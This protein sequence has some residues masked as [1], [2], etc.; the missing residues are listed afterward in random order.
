MRQFGVF[1]HMGVDGISM[2]LIL[3]NSFMTF[4]VVVAGWE[5]IEEKVAGHE[6]LRGVDLELPAKA[7]KLRPR[8]V[9]TLRT[10]YAR[11]GFN[12]ALRE[13]DGAPA[14]VDEADD[15]SQQGALAMA[16]EADQARRDVARIGLRRGQAAAVDV[17]AVAQ[18][19]KG[20]RPTE[21]WYI[22]DS[23]ILTGKGGERRMIFT[24]LYEAFFT[25]LKVAFFGAALFFFAGPRAR[26]AR[27]GL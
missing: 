14:P 18:G 17:D 5:V 26:R 27:R 19:K 21:K 3:L 11:Y 2:P 1:Y 9:D 23:D 22:N 4:L 13:L 16:V 25:Y 24:A 12:A 15:G 6:I 10:L 7:L 20:G 8:D